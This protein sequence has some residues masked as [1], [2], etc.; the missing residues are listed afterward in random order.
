MP[1]RPTIR[2]TDENQTGQTQTYTLSGKLLG[3][4]ECYQFLEDLRDR[5][6]DGHVLVR[7]HMQDVDMINSSGAG[8]LAALAESARKQNGSLTLVGVQ[9]R[10]RKVLEFMRLH[11]FIDLADTAEG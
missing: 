3:T 1:H 10:S 8:I 11:E 7:L 2:V 5:I 6:R 4:P 9:P